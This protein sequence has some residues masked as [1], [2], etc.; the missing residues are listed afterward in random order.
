[1][2]VGDLVRLI[3]TPSPS[4]TESNLNLET[5]IVIGFKGTD[6]IVFWN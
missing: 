6:V 5:G 4:W 2:K 3:P 1:M